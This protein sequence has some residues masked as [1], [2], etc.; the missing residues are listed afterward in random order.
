MVRADRGARHTYQL[1]LS[2]DETARFVAMGPSAWHTEPAELAARLA[3][4]TEPVTVTVSVTLRMYPP[5][6]A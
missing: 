6:V 4:W 3:Q 1:G 5:P 2:R